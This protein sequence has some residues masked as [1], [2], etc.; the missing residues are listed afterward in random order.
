MSLTAKPTSGH[1]FSGWTD[2]CSGLTTVCTVSMS[3][4]RTA[5]A[6]F[7][8]PQQPTLSILTTSLP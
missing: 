3:L 2:A 7:A 8:V 1:T 5:V 6:A 4:A